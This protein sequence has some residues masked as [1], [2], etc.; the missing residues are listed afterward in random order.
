MHKKWQADLTQLFVLKNGNPCDL[1]MFTQKRN[2]KLYL[3]QQ[4]LFLEPYLI[5]FDALLSI[6]VCPVL[7][8]DLY[9]NLFVDLTWTIRFDL[10]LSSNLRSC[11]FPLVDSIYCIFSLNFC[12]WILF[13]RSNLMDFLHFMIRF[14]LIFLMHLV[15][16]T[17][18]HCS[19][20]YSASSFFVL[21]FFF[22]FI[23]ISLSVF[24]HPPFVFFRMPNGTR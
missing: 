22:H 11:I 6:T 12:L 23:I 3:S 9:I 16:H 7:L 10:F 20:H 21:V 19:L 4:M 2:P 17:F 18:S 13:Y 15:D 24:V 1:K 8:A 14:Y 5:I